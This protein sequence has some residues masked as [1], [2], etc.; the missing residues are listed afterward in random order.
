M[1]IVSLLRLPLTLREAWAF[2]FEHD[3]AHRRQ[4]RRQNKKQHATTTYLFDPMRRVNLP[5]SKWH[6]DHQLAHNQMAAG[7]PPLTV[8]I[9]R[10]SNLPPQRT[11]WEFANHHEHYINQS[12]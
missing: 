2:T 6:L 8:Q 4:N 9:L 12:G 3:Q 1:A 5:G 10:D 11:W 7:P